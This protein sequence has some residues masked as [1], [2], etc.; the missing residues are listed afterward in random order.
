MRELKYASWRCLSSSPSPKPCSPPGCCSASRERRNPASP[1]S[2]RNL[3]MRDF[4]KPWRRR[5]GVLTLVMA[6]VF[7]A[8]WVRSLTV[9]DVCAVDFDSFA[10][11]VVSVD[12]NLSAVVRSRDREFI[13]SP[14][15]VASYKFE[16]FDDVCKSLNL[17]RVLANI[18][19]G[20]G[21]EPGG[22]WTALSIPV[23]FFVLP[24]TLLSAWLLLSKQPRLSNPSNHRKD[25]SV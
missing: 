20:K 16:P 1:P 17:N 25:L 9:Q 8:G 24:L 3:T 19:F 11:Y 2:R 21:E 14:P 4:F 10:V 6:C 5:L 7:A 18:R 23:Y 13:W 15:F 22:S 12:H